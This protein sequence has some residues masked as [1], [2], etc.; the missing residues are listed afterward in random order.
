MV[1]VFVSAVV[2]CEELE[3]VVSENWDVQFLITTW[4]SF[5]NQTTLQ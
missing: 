3:V 2:I 5:F 4:V 1:F